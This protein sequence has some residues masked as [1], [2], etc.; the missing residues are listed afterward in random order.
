MDSL[1]CNNP[2]S[3]N[4]RH[5]RTHS[6]EKVSGWEERVGEGR[7][8]HVLLCLLLHSRCH[9]PNTLG[10]D[11][12]HAV[13]RQPLILSLRLYHAA[14]SLNGSGVDEGL[15]QADSSWPTVRRGHRERS[16]ERSGPCSCGRGLAHGSQVHQPFCRCRTRRAAISQPRAQGDFGRPIG[17]RTWPPPPEPPLSSPIQTRPRSQRDVSPGDRGADT[18]LDTARAGHETHALPPCRA[19]KSSL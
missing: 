7:S 9:L 5:R 8:S 12:I 17:L 18:V 10:C 4:W 14:S 6:R 11:P 15:P 1:L 19:V 16:P 13:G 3:I 2:T